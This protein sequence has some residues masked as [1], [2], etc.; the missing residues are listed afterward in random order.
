MTYNQV[1]SPRAIIRLLKQHGSCRGIDCD[2]CLVDECKDASLDEMYE[3]VLKYVEDHP[4][5]MMEYL[6]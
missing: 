4:E 3:C 5:E 1:P 6:L 2:E